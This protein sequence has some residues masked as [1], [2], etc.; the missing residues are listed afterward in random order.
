MNGSEFS[1]SE[2]FAMGGYATFVW[3]SYAITAVV[4]IANI[5]LPLRQRKLIIRRIKRA[6]RREQ[7]QSQ[8]ASLQK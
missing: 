2:F 3:S 5:V 7:Q 1:W 6:R 8:Q 4:L